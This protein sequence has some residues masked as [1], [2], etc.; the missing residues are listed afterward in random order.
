M[1]DEADD[2]VVLRSPL[3]KA[4]GIIGRYP[5]PDESI[6]M[7]FEDVEPRLI[8]MMFVRRPLVVEWWVGN[9]LQQ[10]KELRP[11]IGVGRAPADRVIE[12]RP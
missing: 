11:W 10:R 1:T 6:V 2:D 9:E 5:E 3:D 8:H 4:R 12:K 7:E